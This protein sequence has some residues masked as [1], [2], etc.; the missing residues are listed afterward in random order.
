VASRVA[1]LV[2]R[3][4]GL[5]VLAFQPEV[6]RV[7]SEGRQEVVALST[8]AFCKAMTAVAVFAAL[9]VA[10]YAD[11]VIVLA[12]NESFLG[13]RT[14]LWLLAASIP[15][16]AMTAPLTAVMKAL[17]GVRAAFACDLAWALVYLTLLLALASPLG[18]AGAGVAQL[19]ACVVQLFLA[20]RLAPVRPRVGEMIATAVKAAVCAAVALAPVVALG[21]VGAPRPLAWALALPAAWLFVRATR[22]VRVLSHEERTRMTELLRGHGFARALAG[23]MP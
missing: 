19:S 20:A 4:I 5:P 17:D 23:W 6:T 3:F 1:R 8:R 22:R 10:V 13:A 9:A 7:A 2:N 18:V 16:S 11:D 12:S 15:L 14:T 21:A